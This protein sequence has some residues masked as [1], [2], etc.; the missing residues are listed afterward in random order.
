MV[1]ATRAC[2]RAVFTS[3]QLIMDMS[4]EF[5]SR[6]CPDYHSVKAM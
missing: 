2:Q 3:T 6:N 1:P 4:V 5:I